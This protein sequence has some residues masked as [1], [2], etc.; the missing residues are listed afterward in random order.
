MSMYDDLSTMHICVCVFVVLV[1]VLIWIF[2]YNNRLA[3]HDETQYEKYANR[4][5]IQMQY[6]TIPAPKING[7]MRDRSGNLYNP[8]EHIMRSHRDSDVSDPEITTNGGNMDANQLM[9]RNIETTD[10]KL[11][12][13]VVGSDGIQLEGMLPPIADFESSYMMRQNEKKE[14]I[15]GNPCRGS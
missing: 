6:N 7:T 2:N 15:Y 5:D 1:L 4:S 9:V 14:S 11:A 10:E 3:P 12:R 8:E 13:S